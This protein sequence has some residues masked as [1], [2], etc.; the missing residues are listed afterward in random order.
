V[1]LATAPRHR[2]EDA[3]SQFSNP[4]EK[5]IIAVELDDGDHLIGAAIT[6]GKHE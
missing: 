6:E 2:Q 4:R 5:G 1:F 3:L